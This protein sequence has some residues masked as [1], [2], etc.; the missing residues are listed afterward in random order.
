LNFHSKEAGYVD[1]KTIKSFNDGQMADKKNILIIAPHPDD[2]V[3]GMG[4]TIA[5]KAEEGHNFTIVYVTN[6]AGSIKTDDY[7][8]LSTDELV[9]LRKKEAELS[10]QIL[11]NNPHQAEQIFLSYKSAD[12]FENPE[13]YKEELKQILRKK[14]FNEVYLPYPEDR[15]P[16]HRAVAEL[17]K[18]AVKECTAPSSK[19]ADFYAYETW[20]AIPINDKVI[21]VDIS[22]YYKRKLSAVSCHK[23]QCSITP[24]DEG[25]I[26]KNKYNAVFSS[27]N[28]KNKMEYAELFLKL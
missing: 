20:D 11:L 5:L 16:T 15:H 28:S 6:G 24:F 1:R 9:K 14:T 13:A 23:S 26:A 17:S 18:E 19:L 3:I 21:T 7:K 8:E 12:L 10:I 22:Q 27:I 4:G 2:D 25:I